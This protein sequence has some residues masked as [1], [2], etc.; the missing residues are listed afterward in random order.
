MKAK[1][2][3]LE[4]KKTTMRAPSSN[5]DT[6]SESES[7]SESYQ[8]SSTDSD[9][10][11]SSSSDS[12][13]DAEPE[14]EFSQS[15]DT[16]LAVAFENIRKRKKQQRGDRNTKKKLSHINEGDETRMFAT[17]EI[18]SLGRDDSGN[19][20]VEG[21]V[22]VPSH[23]SHNEKEVLQDESEQHEK[24]N[25]AE[26]E[27]ED[28]VMEGEDAAVEVPPY[29][30]YVVQEVL[31]PEPLVVIMPLQPKQPSELRV[32][33]LEVPPP[34]VDNVV[35]EE[36]Q[37]KPLVVI[38]P[39]QPEQQ[40][41]GTTEVD[42][43]TI[44][45]I[46]V[47]P[48]LTLR[49]WLQPEAETSAAKVPIEATDEIITHV[50]LSMNQEEPSTQDSNQIQ[51][52]TDEDQCKTPEATPIMLKERCFI[53]ATMENDNKYET[54]FQLR[55]PNTIEAMTYNFMT[56]APETCIDMQMVSLV[57][58][59]LNREELQRFQ[60]DVCYVPPEILIRIFQTYGTNYL[61]KKTKMPY[62]VSQLKDQH[63]M[64]LLDKEKLRKH[65]TLFAP[66]LHAHHWWLYVLDVDNKEFYVVDSV[67]GTNT[68]QPRN[69]LH[70]FGCNILNQLRVWAGAQPLLKKQTI[71]LQL[72]CGVY[73]MK[74]MELNEV[75]ALSAAAHTFKLPHSIEEWSQDQLDQF[76]KDIVAKLIMSKENTLNVEAIK[77]AS[78]MTLEAITEA[79]EKM[80]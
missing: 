4:K 7:E 61:D 19:V 70:R 66:I 34:I 74:W 21:P 40:S 25:D 5:R 57:C 27:G 30:E 44:N 69:K 55:G 62:L 53:W 3:K 33:E 71:A 31:Q 38:M 47:E 49:P 59:T 8:S 24:T 54:I 52:T 43:D 35:H 32:T 64:E 75:A 72:S 13:S 11:S 16:P 63:Y 39:L 79:R 76:R 48:E 78:N 46:P 2:D 77:Q 42:P 80:G 60:R 28:A 51:Q 23:P 15:E 68:N 26:V 50:L 29:M 17:F 14:T 37:P 10:E 56:M 65:S 1:K 12:G 45:I 67:F 36:I 73:V 20:A 22:V 9:S 41:A 58:H 18:V 6:E